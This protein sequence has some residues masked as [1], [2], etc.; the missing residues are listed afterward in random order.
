MPALS[1]HGTGR[2]TDS[3]LARVL[4]TGVVAVSIAAVVLFWLLLCVVLVAGRW[5]L[6]AWLLGA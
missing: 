5:R 2:K 3:A 1:S 6:A 4:G